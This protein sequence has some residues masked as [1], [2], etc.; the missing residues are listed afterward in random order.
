MKKKSFIPAGDQAF[1]AGR[2][3]TE[4]NM[5]SKM[6]QGK[7]PGYVNDFERL[8]NVQ[9]ASDCEINMQIY[10]IC[11][12]ERLNIPYTLDVFGNISATKGEANKYICLC[13]HI[14]T[15]HDIYRDYKITLNEG[16]FYAFAG[17]HQVGTGGDDKCGVFALLHLLKT[18]TKPV[19]VVFFSREETGCIGSGEFD[20]EVFNDVGLII[21][22]DRKN[23][24]DLIT[25][26]N[27]YTIS[28]HCAEFLLPIAKKYGY[29]ETSGLITDVFTIQGRMNNPVSAINVSCG[30]YNPHTNSEVISLKDFDNC[31]RFV[32]SIINKYDNE[33]GYNIEYNY[34]S[35]DYTT[36][37]RLDWW[38]YNNWDRLWEMTCFDAHAL[39]ETENGEIQYDEFADM[40]YRYF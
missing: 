20:M 38:L 24:S 3:L 28:D 8:L 40:F 18:S 34:Q 29:R 13:A 2:G 7:Y 1:P 17:S 37:E 30:Y 25:C 16:V 31:L 14:D 19:K 10:I 6:K 36:A 27:D 32:T 26:Y 11:Y 9:S 12:L 21:G 33:T 23:K 35:G 39:Y 5:P 4:P 22:I 15:V